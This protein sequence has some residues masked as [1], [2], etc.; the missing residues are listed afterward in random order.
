MHSKI[1]LPWIGGIDICPHNMF[2]TMLSLHKFGIHIPFAEDLMEKYANRQG[3][4]YCEY[5]Y[6]EFRVD[7]KSFGKEGNAMFVT[8][9]MDIREGRDLLDRK[10]RSRHG[11]RWTKVEFRRGF[12]CAAFEEMADTEFKFDE[13]LTKQNEKDLCT[14]TPW[15][16][17]ENIEVSYD[18]V[19]RYFA[20]RNGRFVYLPRQRAELG[21]SSQPDP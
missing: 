11:K 13:L 17:P 20:V 10:W 16:W 5:C 7:F 18:N 21:S 2:A 14:K 12:I 9:W 1:P 4:I 3:I 8:R 19:R 15:P 6:T